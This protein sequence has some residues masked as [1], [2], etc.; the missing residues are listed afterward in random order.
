MAEGKEEGSVPT[1]GALMAG[2]ESTEACGQVPFPAPTATDVAG[3]GGA[4]QV[5]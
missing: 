3:Y 1:P 4:G 2:W 5:W